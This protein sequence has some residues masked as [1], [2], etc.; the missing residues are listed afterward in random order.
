MK[1]SNPVYDGFT[2][3]ARTEAGYVNIEFYDDVDNELEHE[4][5]DYNI[6]QENINPYA[7]TL[8]NEI[9][10]MLRLLW[11]TRGGYK[12][13]FRVDPDEFNASMWH[14]GKG[15]AKFGATYK[16]DIDAD[17]N[18]DA[19]FDMVLT[20]PDNP[21]EF[22]DFSD[23]TSNSSLRAKQLAK[24]DWGMDSMPSDL[25]NEYLYEC[26]RMNKELDFSFDLQWKQKG[27][28]HVSV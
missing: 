9:W 24:P 5:F 19:D 3:A 27:N 15:L 18:W 4:D 20:Q 17:G 1:V 11:K 22:Q 16:F 8:T 21:F 13:E 28:W 14:G 25:K 12:L 7:D 2:N 6:I 23:Q 10:P 26:A